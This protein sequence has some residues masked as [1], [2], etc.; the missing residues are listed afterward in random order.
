MPMMTAM[1]VG[2]VRNLIDKLINV[3]LLILH[4][5]DNFWFLFLL[6]LI[7][8]FAA[9]FDT[10]IILAVWCNAENNDEI[11]HFVHKCLQKIILPGENIAHIVFQWCEHSGWFLQPR[12][13]CIAHATCI[14]FCRELGIGFSWNNQIQNQVNAIRVKQMNKINMK[15][16]TPQ[17]NYGNS[18]AKCTTKEWEHLLRMRK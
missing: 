1:A 5:L 7:L 11:H 2:N 16:R 18:R 8:Q 13:L 12:Y 10:T 15:K 6:F 17:F 3:W 4:H 9:F 14:Q